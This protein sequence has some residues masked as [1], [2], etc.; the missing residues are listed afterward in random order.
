M[1]VETFTEAILIKMSDTGKVQ[2]KFIISMCKLFLM[3]RGRYNFL[4]FARYGLL[5]ELTYRLN[6]NKGFDFRQ[7]NSQLITQY[8]SEKLVWVFDPSYLPKSGKHTPGVGYFWSGC[9]GAM[10]KGLEICGLAVADLVNHTAFHYHAGQTDAIKGEQNLL[11]FYAK[12]ILRQVAALKKVSK[13]V[14]VDAFFSKISFVNALCEHDLSVVSRMR[15][16][17]YLR[18]PFKGVQQG[19]KGRPKEFDGK[20]DPRNVSNSHFKILRQTETE[21]LYEGIAHIRA[22][23]RWCSVVIRQ[24]LKDGKVHKAFIYFS[25]DC[26][27]T[28]QQVIE[29]YDIR[30]QIEFL[31]RDSKQFLGLTQ[32]QSRQKKAIAFHVNMALTV[33]NIAKAMHWISIPKTDRPPFSMADIKTQYINELILDRLICLYG[34]DPNVEKNNPDIRK[35]YDLGRIAA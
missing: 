8:C 20:V 34:K 5:N 17:S 12:L 28:G 18:Y 27:M 14:V 31:Y 22:L 2:R 13:I 32:C 11:A 15:S 6:F 25:T 3:L 1:K 33:L 19:G 29:R 23:K 21:V 30:F 26:K 9:A 4:N 35:L 7:F 24:T 10:K 16:D